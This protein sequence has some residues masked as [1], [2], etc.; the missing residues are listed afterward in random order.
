MQRFQMS[1]KSVNLIYGK[2]SAFN[3]LQTP[4]DIQKPSPCSD[5]PDK[6]VFCTGGRRQNSGYAGG[7]SVAYDADF[8]DG[9]DF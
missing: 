1:G 7:V 6:K 9:W 5:I 4:E 2:F 3:F 8:T